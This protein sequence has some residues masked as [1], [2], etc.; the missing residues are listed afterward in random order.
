MII[1]DLC[2]QAKDCV[3]KEIESKGTT[4]A[5]NVGAHYPKGLREKA[6]PSST[7][8]PCS[9]RILTKNR[10]HVRR[11]PFRAN[12]RRSGVPSTGHTDPKS[13]SETWRSGSSDN[14]D[15]GPL[16]RGRVRAAFET[17]R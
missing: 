8:I 17:P 11:G 12:R 1:C 5:P 6:D 4:S 7:A 16:V 3:Q 10:S 15:S 2:G 9:C 14:G 13:T